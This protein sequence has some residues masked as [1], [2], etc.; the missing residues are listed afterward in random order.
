MTRTSLTAIK[1]TKYLEKLENDYTKMRSIKQNEMN[2]RFPA[3]KYVEYFT[4]G[5]KT[6]MLKI[7]SIVIKSLKSKSYTDSLQVVKSKILRLG[8]R[9]FLREFIQLYFFT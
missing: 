2:I 4:P 6:M 5:L 8:K 1:T 9:V 7:S 3:L